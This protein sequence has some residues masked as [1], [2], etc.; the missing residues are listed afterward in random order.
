VTLVLRAAR[1]VQAQLDSA[2]AHER[3]V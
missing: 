2:T 3:A 1:Q